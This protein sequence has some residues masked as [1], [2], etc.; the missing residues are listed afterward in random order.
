MDTEGLEVERP[1]LV[2]TSLNTNAVGA[3]DFTDYLLAG[4][5]QAAGYSPVLTFDKKAAKSKTHRLLSA[6]AYMKNNSFHKTLFLAFSQSLEAVY[7]RDIDLDTLGE[8]PSIVELK[9]DE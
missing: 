8:E 7:R 1:E 3:A 5:V 9:S 6:F 2:Q 4:R